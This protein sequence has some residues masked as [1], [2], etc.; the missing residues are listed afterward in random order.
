ML[1]IKY[2]KIRKCIRVF[3]I[4]FHIFYD[5]LKKKNQCFIFLEFINYRIIWD[6]S[7][8]KRKVT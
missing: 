1:C 4:L 3:Q 5:N 2:N 6:F 8:Y 7:L